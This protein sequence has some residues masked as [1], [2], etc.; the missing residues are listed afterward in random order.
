MHTTNYLDELNATYPIRRTEAQKSAFREY[1][2][3]RMSEFGYCSKVET[4]ADRK[5]QNVV[6]GDPATAKIVLTAHYDTPASAIFPNLMLPRNPLLYYLCQLLPLFLLVGIALLG[7][8]LASLPFNKNMGVFLGVYIILYYALFF[9]CYRMRSNPHNANDNTSGVAT[10]LTALANADPAHKASVAAILFDN[11]EKGKMGSKAYFKDHQAEMKQKP[12]INLDCVGYGE[13]IIFVAKEA[14]ESD[15]LYADLKDAFLQDS[16]DYQNHFYPM[17]GSNANSD[18]KSFPKGI[19]C[20]T[21]KRSRRGI[22]YT[23][24]IHTTKDRYANPANIT[25]IAE[26][27]SEFV[28]QID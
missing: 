26:R 28:N 5:N 13:H 23:P 15:P 1:I 10:V 4:T 21:C 12:V 2:V 8:F 6:I 24:H 20:M 3:S 18:Y 11:E 25:Y 19:G 7:G 9:I 16:D 14:A 27:L 17:K 22:Y